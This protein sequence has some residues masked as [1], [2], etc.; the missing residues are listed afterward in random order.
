MFLSV[1]QRDDA[2]GERFAIVGDGAAF[3]RIEY[4]LAHDE[5]VAV[6]RLALRGS[7]R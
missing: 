3:A 2:R 6:E 1:R 4:A 5:T 7:S